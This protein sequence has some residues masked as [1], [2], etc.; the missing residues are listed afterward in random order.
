MT[1]ANPYFLL[2]TMAAIALGLFSWFFK[3]KAKSRVGFSAPLQFAQTGGVFSKTADLLPLIFRILAIVLLT[4]ALARPQEVNR[5]YSDP[6]YGVDIMLC[7]DTSTSMHALDFEPFNRLQAAKKTAKEFISK[8]VNDRIGITVFAGSALLVCP[9]TLD[10]QSL[11]E[12]LSSV[13]IGMLSVDGTAIGDAIATAVNH[14]KES[15]AK[16]KVMVLLTDGRNNMGEISNPVMAAEA[17][18]KFGIKIYTIGTAGRGPAKF[19]AGNSVFG[20]K[21]V[22]LKEDLDEKTLSEI[23]K[24]SG[25]TFYRAKNYRQL[26]DI[27]SKI[28]AL[29]KTQVQAPVVLDYSDKYFGF[30]LPAVIFL[31][32]EFLLKMFV[33]IRIP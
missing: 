19:P 6:A 28:N 17:A 21:Y 25:G 20:P 9:L 26:Q 12:F 32:L 14:L 5:S 2:L 16:S 7:I 24:V 27:Y 33:F 4:I 8:R 29:E 11:L 3:L 18:E 10:Y 31:I 15:K 1:F 22:Y 13:Q 30:I 23:A